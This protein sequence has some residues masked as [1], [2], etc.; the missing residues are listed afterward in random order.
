MSQ[1]IDGVQAKVRWAYQHLRNLNDDI[2]VRRKIRVQPDSIR[3]RANTHANGQRIIIFSV[4]GNPPAVD[5][6]FTIQVG[7][8]IHQL[9]SAL[10]HLVYELVVAHTKKPPTFNS[11]FPIIGRGRTKNGVPKQAADVYATN[12]S[13]LKQNISR[14]AMT[15]IDDLQP[16]KLDAASRDNDALWILSELDNTYK[17]RLLHL[18]VHRIVLYEATLR[19]NG[20]ER[21]VLFKPKIR[22]EDGAE[23]GR[24]VIDDPAFITSNE[25]VLVDG[26]TVVQIAL[27]EVINK[28]N[29][30]V[31]D[32]LADLHTRVQ[33]LI[34]DF[35]SAG[36]FK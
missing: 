13:T 36:E 8:A 28:K 14:T 11:A 18:I 12:V 33:R 10:D 25:H 20:I 22:F 4:K 7:E 15:R 1:P 35:I 2:I 26:E 29:V 34:D 16:F 17:H 5:L 6:S 19:S 27:S 3:V 9:R 32:C 23:I 30:P 21:N 24:T 31:F